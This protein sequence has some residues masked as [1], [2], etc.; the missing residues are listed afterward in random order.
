[1]E[2]SKRLT[3]VTALVGA[4]KKMADVGTDHG[5]IPIHL[6]RS[7]ICERA[8]AMDVNVGP[9]QR[10]KEHIAAY[11]LNEQIETRLSDGVQ[12]LRVGECEVVV[13][14]GMGGPLTIKILEEG[15]KVFCELKEFVLQPQSEIEKVRRYLY[16]NTYSIVEEDM[17][18]E[19]GKFYPM[20]RVVNA[21][22]DPYSKAEFCFG[23]IL[24]EKQHS[25]LKCF[26][27]KELY[28]KEK[29]K[30][31]L[32]SMDGA[33]IEVRMAEIE[34]ELECIKEALSVYQ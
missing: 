34:S 32:G 30:D 24:L 6:L 8:I 17:V 21:Q 9:L 25:V 19:D 27:E 14:A 5:Y 3:A 2:L 10:A 20:M 18:F 29:I 28:K 31:S 4:C 23:K 12:A 11:G 7:G 1:M 22:S 13:V 33:H 16:D 26:L 15:K